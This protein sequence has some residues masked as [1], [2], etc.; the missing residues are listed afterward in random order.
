MSKNKIEEQ[1]K[2]EILKAENK[3]LKELAK[4]QAAE[5]RKLKGESL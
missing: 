3:A 5:L 2:I 4:K 1:R